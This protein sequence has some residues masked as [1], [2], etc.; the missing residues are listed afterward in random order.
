MA[1]DYLLYVSQADGNLTEADIQEILEK[2]RR[3]NEGVEISGM[4]LFVE[5]RDGRRGSFMQ[6]LEGEAG[7]LE[8][9]RSRIFADRRHHT[10]IVLEQGKKPA[11]DFGDWS[12][13]YKSAKSSDFADHPIFSGLGED[14]FAER[15]AGKE[16]AGSC[17]FLVEFWDADD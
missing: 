8:V 13:A 12:M 2:S 17:D 4:L 7:E 1:I 16:I 14:H 9:L 3:Y 5:G 6:L 15:C 10:K 11:R